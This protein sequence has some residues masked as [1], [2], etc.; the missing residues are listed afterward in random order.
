[1]PQLLECQS[2]SQV[3]HEQPE[4]G[5]P[6]DQDEVVEM[7]LAM[8]KNTI[9]GAFAGFALHTNRQSMLRAASSFIQVVTSVVEGRR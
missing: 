5:E 6:K 4:D 1:M 9:I 8:I 2:T 7:R 3:Y